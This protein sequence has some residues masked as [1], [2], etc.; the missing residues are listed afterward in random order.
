M[1]GR[2]SCG[3][4]SSGALI[5]GACRGAD[6]ED[7]FLA[8]LNAR[9]LWVRFVERNRNDVVS[10]IAQ[11]FPYCL[12]KCLNEGIATGLQTQSVQVLLLTTNQTNGSASEACT[13]TDAC[14]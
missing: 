9:L 13:P 12:L 3:A 2:L 6:A 5:S 4:L 11:V 8:V 7:E 14:V 1:Q 10:C